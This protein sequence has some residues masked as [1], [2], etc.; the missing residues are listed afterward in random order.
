MIP[1][2]LS[3]L[4]VICSAPPADADR[5]LHAPFDQILK[6]NVRDERIDYLNIREHSLENLSAYLDRLEATDLSALS[7]QQQL[8]FYINLYNATMI[9]TVIGRYR[10]DYS[11]SEDRFAV[12]DEPLVRLNGKRFSLNDLEHRIVR[13]TF[14]DPRIHAVLVCAARSC[15]P[16]LPRAY[17]ANDLDKLLEQNMHRFLTDPS[18]N[19]IDPAT[20]RL[21][22]SQIFNW[23]ADDFGGRDAVARYVAR[24]TKIDPDQTSVSFLAYSWELNITAQKDPGLDE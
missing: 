24:Y 23:Y 4:L 17:L 19:R 1:A 18:R 11:V 14:K 16:L 6:E 3:V 5:D 2:L 10:K 13:P 15:P 21:Q 22:L 20:D 9:Q 12:F 7:R 8:A